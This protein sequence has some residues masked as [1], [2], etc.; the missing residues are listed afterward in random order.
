MICLLLQIAKKYLDIYVVERDL[1]Y[2]KLLE[3]MIS[4]SNLQVWLLSPRLKEI[5]YN[6]NPLDDKDLYFNF[7]L[8]KC[9][10]RLLL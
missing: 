8:S 2:Y 1:V 6:Y 7:P 9:T 5:V 4:P 3:Q 10:F